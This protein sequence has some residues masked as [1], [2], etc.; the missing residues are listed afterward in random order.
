MTILAGLF[1]F[2]SLPLVA[3]PHDTATKASVIEKTC[4][5]CGCERKALPDKDENAYENTEQYKMLDDVW[6][7]FWEYDLGFDQ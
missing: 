7:D 2:I 3:D 6:Y 4:V 1:L 5:R